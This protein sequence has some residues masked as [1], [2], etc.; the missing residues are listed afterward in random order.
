MGVFEGDDTMREAN[1]AQQARA[2]ARRI[3]RRCGGPFLSYDHPKAKPSDILREMS[4]LREDEMRGHLRSRAEM[5]ANA[6][7]FMERAPARK[8]T[9]EIARHLA[10]DAADDRAVWYPMS[11]HGRLA[12]LEWCFTEL[13]MD[14]AE[15][16][17]C[18]ARGPVKH[19]P[20]C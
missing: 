5:L 6:A 16:Q 3:V 9:Q 14:A 1:I 11:Y 18:L 10:I 4:A 19:W 8:A 15:R 13:G 17:A 7:E 2:E 20:S 12:A